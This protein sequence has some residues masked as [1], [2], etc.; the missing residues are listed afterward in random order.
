MS[1]PFVY[2]PEANGSMNYPY[3][4]NPYH[5]SHPYFATTPTGPN[6]PFLP[7]A[8]LYP[9]SPFPTHAELAGHTGTPNGAFNP[10]SVLWPDDS[11]TYESPYAAS[12]GNGGQP[13]ARQRTQS[14]TGP[15]QQPHGSPF[16]APAQAPAFLHANSY[17][18]HGHRRSNSHGAS[19]LPPWVQ[20]QPGYP[21][22]AY[23]AFQQ[24]AYPQQIH[25][26]LNGEAPSPDF[27]FDMAAPF[28][29]LRRVPNNPAH[30][31]PIPTPELQIPAF[32]PP[33]TALRILHPQLPFWP[34]D[35]TPPPPPTPAHAAAGPP[36]LSLGDILVALHKSLHTRI[37]HA[38]WATL[39]PAA[40]Q[41]VTR[42]F[43]ARCHNEA[44]KS[45]APMH[46][47]SDVEHAVRSQGV[48]RVDF[49]LGRTVLRGLVKHPGDPEGVVRLVTA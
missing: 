33:R 9:T 22:S 36:P 28:L 8:T 7:P 3:G 23:P 12:W 13:Y 24:P 10:N 17:T 43:A 26:F 2:V 30:S 46:A 21:A 40:E 35:L 1:S 47:M 11:H 16:L 25:P 49:L 18:G 48:K 27:H 29:P 14:W 39:D 41:A 19:S 38:D 42:A 15:A 31:M 32:H 6:T 37:S 45:G 4:Q 44:A 5:I 34:V 20:P